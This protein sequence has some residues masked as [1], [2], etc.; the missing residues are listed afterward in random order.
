[1][2]P[3]RHPQVDAYIEGLSGFQKALAAE[4]RDL[5]H[6]A[7]PE[8]EET[9]KRKVQPYFVL[10]GNVAAL[11]GTMDHLNVFLYD[12]GAPDPKGIITD[13]HDNATG[14]QIALYEDEQMDREAFVELIRAIAERNRAGGW[15]KLG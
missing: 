13:G 10:D 9:I 14:R 11:L 5:I 15:R 7:D 6:Q 2:A 12:P 4:I 8:I 3:E 1:M